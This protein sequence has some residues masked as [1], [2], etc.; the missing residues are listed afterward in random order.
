MSCLKGHDHFKKMVK[1]A[2]FTKVNRMVFARIIVQSVGRPRVYTVQSNW[3]LMTLA[4]ATRCAHNYS[5]R[6]SVKLWLPRT[7]Y[8]RLSY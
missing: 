2:K 3:I 6:A 7:F 5:L 1:V 8:R 4:T